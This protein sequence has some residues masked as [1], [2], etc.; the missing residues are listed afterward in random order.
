MENKWI[1]ERIRRLEA[2]QPAEGEC[3]IRLDA[4]ESPFAPTEEMRDAFDEALREVP[5]QR[6]PDPAAAALREAFAG[7]YG[8]SSGNV[9]A[10]N[11]SDEL[12]FLICTAFLL[13]GDHM[14]VTAPDFSMYAFYG[15]LVGA[16][17][18]TFE[19]DDNLCMD[20]DRLTAFL[21]EENVK[22]V[23]LSNPCNPTGQLM[24][25]EE[26]LSVIRQTDALVIA[27]EAYMEFC[28]EGES[29][30][31]FCGE[32]P[33]LIVLKT[34]SKAFG[35]A[36]ARLGFAV[37]NTELIEAVRKVKSP[38]NLNAVSQKL[39]EIILSFAVIAE[40][41]IQKIRESKAALECALEREARKAHYRVYPSATNFVLLRFADTDGAA[42][43]ARA[44]AMFEALKRDGILVRYIL[45]DCLRITAGTEQ[46]N[47]ALLCS[48]FAHL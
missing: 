24:R 10:G 16:E 34:L 43:A 32:Y 15:S 21:R 33:N 46:E 8:L 14:A 40:S 1:P 44:L 5:F 47:E 12:I 31:P 37:G 19:K 35:F 29:V 9:V 25:R 3:R 6:Y 27:D 11:G 2:Y 30:L 39:G 48:F 38:Y 26:M 41:N 23:I 45:G 20:A 7:R 4:N 42:G 18:V 13:P 17:I 22:L 28:G 36:A